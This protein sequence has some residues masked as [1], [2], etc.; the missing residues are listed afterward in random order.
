[1]IHKTAQ[2]V[3][4][5]RLKNC[6]NLRHFECVGLLETLWLTTQTETPCGDIG[7]LS[8][9]EIA[10][11]LEWDR[12]PADELIEALVT[13]GWLDRDGPE[14]APSS[15]W[16]LL[17][18]NWPERCPN[19]VKGNLARHDRGFATKGGCHSR[20]P[21]QPAQGT[22]LGHGP[23]KPNQTKPFSKP[24]SK[25]LTEGGG[26]APQARDGQGDDPPDREACRCKIFRSGEAECG[27]TS[28]TEIE[29]L[30]DEMIARERT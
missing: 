9:D 10:G 15:G 30:V 12:T 29:Q 16:R 23:T 14:Y 11:C 21:K 4:F 3:K 25:G 24:P 7:K 27:V 18:H 26:V 17:V 8:D 19:Y 13:T 28:E 6:L 1:M 22:P 2:L 5:K 20:P